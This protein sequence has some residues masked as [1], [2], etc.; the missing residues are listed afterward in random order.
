MTLIVVLVISFVA[1]S[2]VLALVG[3]RRAARGRRL[4][5]TL[6]VGDAQTAPVPFPPTEHLTPG[7]DPERAAA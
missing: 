7:R 5:I 1:V 4:E 6:R 3:A 2:V